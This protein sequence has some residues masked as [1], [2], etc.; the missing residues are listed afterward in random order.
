MNHP[1]KCYWC[2]EPATSKE[3]V[4]PENIF[5]EEYRAKL[6]KVDSCKRHNEEFSKLDERM[7]Y[8]MVLLGDDIITRKYFEGTVMRGLS[9]PQGAK[10]TSDLASNRFV[11][12]GRPMSSESSES[13]D[14]YFEKICRGIYFQ[15][16]P[17]KV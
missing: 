3:H 7:R 1:F 10:L 2:G 17:G 5:P 14:L 12:Y 16:C 9:R 6:L 4:P 13:W 15:W 11:H 8:H